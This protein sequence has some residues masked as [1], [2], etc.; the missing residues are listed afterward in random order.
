MTGSARH[1]RRRGFSIVEASVAVLLTGVTLAAAFTTL[2]S[3]GRA[4][5]VGSDVVRG[6]LLAQELMAEIL[7]QP[8]E[9]PGQGRGTFGQSSAEA[10]A[11]NRSLYDDVDDYHGWS[12]S[13]PQAKDGSPIAGLDHWTRS[14]Q[15]VWTDGAGSVSVSDTRIKQITITVTHNGRSVGRAVALRSAGWDEMHGQGEPP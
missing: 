14:V 2:A 1:R 11:G 7:V 8:Y 5:T 13:P 9:G 15:V 10:G 4:R 12:A 6:G 3:I